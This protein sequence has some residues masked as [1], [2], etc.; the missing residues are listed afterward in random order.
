MN[1]ISESLFS[2]HL[3]AIDRGTIELYRETQRE[4]ETHTHTKV[5]REVGSDKKRK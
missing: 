3:L 1:H 5:M 4:R 2:G